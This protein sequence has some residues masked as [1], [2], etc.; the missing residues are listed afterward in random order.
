MHILHDNYYSNH[1]VKQECIMITCES[2]N[3]RLICLS[4]T[5]DMHSLVWLSNFLMLFRHFCIYMGPTPR[6]HGGKEL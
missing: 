3:T 4:L 5:Y 2:H 1:V 6:A